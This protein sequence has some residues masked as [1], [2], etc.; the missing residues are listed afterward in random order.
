[1]LPSSS[2]P[3]STDD[4]LPPNPVV[5]SSTFSP[6]QPK[7]MLK[8]GAATVPVNPTKRAKTN[9]RK[10]TGQKTMLTPKDKSSVLAVK[11]PNQPTASQRIHLRTK[12]TC[13]SLKRM[14]RT[15]RQRSG[16]TKLN[17]MEKNV[18]GMKSKLY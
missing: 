18:S 16:S 11:N 12:C 10:K 13:R 3:L 9:K 1:M 8:R 5:P 15:P 7:L 4:E 17:L 14:L 6:P 2:S